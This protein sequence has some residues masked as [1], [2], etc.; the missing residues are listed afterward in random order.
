MVNNTPKEIAENKIDKDNMMK[1]THFSITNYRSIT[2]AHK[3]SLHSTTILIGKNNEGKSN[4][5]KG[6]NAAMHVLDRRGL[7]P[8]NRNLRN[9]RYRNIDDRYYYWERDFPVSLRSRSSGTQTIF[10]LDFE[11]EPEEILSF[12]EVV[13]SKINGFL[14]MEIRIGRDNQPIIKIKNKRGAGATILN[15]KINKITSFIASNIEFNY[16]PTI[17]TDSDTLDVVRTMLSRQLKN[18]EDND[19]YLKAIDTIRILQEPLLRDLEK[20][21]MEPLKE[22]LPNLVEVKIS[23]PDTERRVALRN[24]FEVI[25]DDGTATELA[26]KGD[27]VK[28]LAALSM[29]KS[30]TD[31]SGASI[32]AI[33]EPESHLHPGAIHQLNDVICA[34]GENHQVIITTHNPLFVDRDDVKSNIIVDMGKAVSARN[35]ESIRNV[36][37]I[38]ASD[39]LVNANYVLIVEGAEDV[40]A[41]KAMLPRLSRKLGKAIANNLFVIEEIGGAGNLSYKAS[42][43][44][45][46]LCKYHCF[47]DNDEAGKKAISKALEDGSISTNSYTLTNC[48]GFNESEFEDCIDPEVYK[49]A[50]EDEYG[51]SLDN[52]KFKGNKKWS[53]RVKRAAI[54]QGKMWDDKLE[55]SIKYTVAKCIQDSKSN[56]LHSHHKNSIESLVSYLENSVVI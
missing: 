37:G 8:S 48:Q 7:G 49:K 45:N 2:T 25:I 15:K 1:L 39:N 16:I 41:F 34:L 43:L 22:F 27:G 46:S 44:R 11:L 42:L 18:L 54:N 4:I 5:L 26:Y 35:I 47:L 24:D 36:M 51:F 23:I 3:I 38:K 9:S 17:R 31:P 14:P 50:V 10:A 19:D 29:L 6:L 28:N 20:Q 30:R 40:I 56:C 32:I 21:L 53:E 55:S 52:P 12:Q 33:E 13:G